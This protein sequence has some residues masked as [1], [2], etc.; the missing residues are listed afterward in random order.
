MIPGVEKFDGIGM[1]SARTRIVFAR[2]VGVKAQ[3][4]AL[5]EAQLQAASSV[6]DE[7]LA[8]EAKELLAREDDL[9]GP[10]EAAQPIPGGPTR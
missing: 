10:A 2:T 3:D 4:R 5:F 6:A 8:S 1:T 9:F 7:D